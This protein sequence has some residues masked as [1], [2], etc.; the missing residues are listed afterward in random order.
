MANKQ[1][2]TVSA[3]AVEAEIA[4]HLERERLAREQA[5]AERRVGILRAIVTALGHLPARSTEVL[6]G[7]WLEPEPEALDAIAMLEAHGAATRATCYVHSTG[8]GY[9]LIVAE[10]RVDGVNFRAQYRRVATEAEIEAAS[11]GDV[12]GPAKPSRCA[13]V[14][15]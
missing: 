1:S 14:A 9:T 2:K 10:A 12:V 13:E 7:V 3:A 8:S 6:L 5:A 15:L 4:G 11:R